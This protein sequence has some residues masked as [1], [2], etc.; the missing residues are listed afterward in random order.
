MV[1]NVSIEE[2]YIVRKVSS[3]ESKWLGSK[4]REDHIMMNGK[5]R[6]RV[7]K[8]ESRVNGMKDP[9]SFEA[10]WTWRQPVRT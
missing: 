4:Y 5:Y 8:R 6:E 3:E 2:N 1:G 7:W 10:D 9:L